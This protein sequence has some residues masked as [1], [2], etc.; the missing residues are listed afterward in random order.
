MKSFIPTLFILIAQLCNAQTADTS[1]NPIA[2][3]TEFRSVDT[4]E[5]YL[6]NTLVFGGTFGTPGIFNIIGGYYGKKGSL[7]AEI[8]GVFLPVGIQGWVG[9]QVNLSSI[10]SRSENFLMELSLVGM[11]V[12]VP[13]IGH[14]YGRN[15]K[16]LGLGISWSMNYSGFFL[17]LGY[18]LLGGIPVI[19][20][21]Y[22]Y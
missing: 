7:R 17:E 21:G 18:T 15:S 13:Y 12:F 9:T 14:D 10:L 11:Y 3:G 22:V 1:A 19:Q 16:T 4:S 8:G 20:I 2:V 6:M 5:V